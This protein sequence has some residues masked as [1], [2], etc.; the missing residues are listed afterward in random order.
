[1]LRN[2][3]SYLGF[4]DFLRTTGSGN[5]AA[6]PRLIAAEPYARALRDLFSDWPP[7]SPLPT[8]IIDNARAMLETAITDR[9]PPEGWDAFEGFPEAGW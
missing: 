2:L 5:E 3:D 1:M 7:S 4:V 6:N 8:A 9:P